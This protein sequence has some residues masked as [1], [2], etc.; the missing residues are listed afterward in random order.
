MTPEEVLPDSFFLLLFLDIIIISL[1]IIFNLIWLHSA[2]QYF[3]CTFPLAILLPLLLLLLL[4]LLSNPG[5]LMNR[6]EHRS[7]GRGGHF[8][9]CILSIVNLEIH[10]SFLEIQNFWNQHFFVKPRFLCGNLYFY[11]E[12]QIS[13]LE[14][15]ISLWK[16]RFFWGIQISFFNSFWKYVHE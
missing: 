16:S 13:F 6:E 15:S 14:I 2:A 12:I 4:L 9:L 5:K 8:S 7:T 1:S 10:F 11:L 3:V